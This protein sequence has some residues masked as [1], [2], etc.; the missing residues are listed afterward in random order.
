MMAARPRKT[1]FKWELTCV[2]RSFESA[3][4]GK[5]GL[6]ASNLVNKQASNQASNQASSNGLGVHKCATTRN[7]HVYFF[8]ATA[9][10]NNGKACNDG[11]ESNTVWCCGVV[12]GCLH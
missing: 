12:P 6:S 2:V 1:N 5:L 4:I 3:P 10:T 11:T 8:G 7:Q 9:T